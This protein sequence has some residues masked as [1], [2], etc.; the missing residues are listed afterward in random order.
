MNEPAPWLGRTFSFDFPPDLH[1]AFRARLRGAAVRLEELTLNVSESCL[2][3]KPGGA[4]SIKE[5]AGHLC[6]LEPL[7]TARVEEFLAG[8]ATLSAA[9]LLNVR[10]HEA[11]H[12]DRPL[13]EVL[14]AFR[15]ARLAL[16]GRLDRLD[17]QDFARTA[18][19]PRLKVTIRL[20]DHLCFVAEHDDHHLARIWSLREGGNA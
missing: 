7:W 6:D 12:N 14:A 19:H 16:M 3:R 17:P 18:M 8:A 10:T 15:A 13:D 4:W 1:P 20:V 2:I 11:G 5:H 9:D